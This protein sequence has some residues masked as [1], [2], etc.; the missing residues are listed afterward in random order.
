MLYTQNARTAR[1]RDFLKIQV[2]RFPV[3]E[4]LKWRFDAVDKIKLIFRI[5]FYNY[6]SKNQM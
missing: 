3:F 2:F 5:A 1:I 6:N 4:E